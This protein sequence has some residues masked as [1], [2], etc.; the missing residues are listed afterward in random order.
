MTPG[1]FEPVARVSLLIRK[2]P[3]TV[4]RYFVEPEL[5]T[6]FWLGKASAPLQ[7]GSSAHWDFLVPGAS[8]D[9]VVTTLQEPSELGVRSADG[10]LITWT[11]AAHGEGETLV[12]I[13]QRGFP[14]TAEEAVKAALE[15]VSGFTLVLAEL[16]LLLEQGRALGLVRDKAQMISEHLRQTR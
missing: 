8:D 4:F 3:S 10:S 7:P 15:A 5:L 6:Q 13:E 9:V 14:G 16:K 11:F 12:K 2:P 1:D